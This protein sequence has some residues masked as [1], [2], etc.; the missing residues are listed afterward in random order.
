[1]DNKN[2]KWCVYILE[3]MDESLYTGITNDLEKRMAAHE[4]GNGSKYVKRKGF[5]QLLH[6]IKAD[7]KSSASKMEYAIKKL[8]R[9]E[10]ITYFM[11]HKDILF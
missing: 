2:K 1:M 10:K 4:S 7:D 8:P 11:K 9:N 3:C 5:L 6:A